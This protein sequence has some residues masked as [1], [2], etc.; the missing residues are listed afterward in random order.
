MQ[1]LGGKNQRDS[2]ISDRVRHGTFGSEEELILPTR[3]P[4]S[5]DDHV[6]LGGFPTLDHQFAN[7]PALW[8]DRF[9]GQCIVDRGHRC[10]G[11]PCHLDRFEGFPCTLL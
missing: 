9:V 5:R 1:I 6:G 8:V 10:E 2:T 11:L 7:Q 3:L 4:R